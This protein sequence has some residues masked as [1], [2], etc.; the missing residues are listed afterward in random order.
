MSCPSSGFITAPEARKTAKGDMVINAEISAIQ[1]KILDAIHTCSGVGKFSIVING[2]TPITTSRGISGINVVAAGSNY[3]SL[4]PTVTVTSIDGVDFSATVDVDDVTGEIQSFLV[5]NVGKEYSIGDVVSVSH[6]GGISGSPFAGSV[7]H[8]SEE[9]S[10]DASFSSDFTIVNSS[11][12]TGINVGEILGITITDPGT[13]YFNTPHLEL[14]DPAG[15]GSGFVG[16]LLLSSPTNGVQ[17]VH[18]TSHGANYSAG[19]AAVVRG[20]TTGT[21][22]ALTAQA[23]AFEL[24]V[25]SV[26]YFEVWAKLK[27]DPVIS[28]QLDIIQD[29]FSQKGYT[30][31]AKT[32][33][34]TMNTIQWQINW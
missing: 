29:Y 34:S 11:L 10:F 28:L 21:A 30:I 13:R 9:A 12:T 25:D 32:N 23:D 27:T 16:E 3:V 5:N 19:T 24:D 15:T 8:V 26:Y 33:P 4:T 17:S 22:A 20:I 1:Q 6:A 7:S 18:I 2:G 14:I 31:S